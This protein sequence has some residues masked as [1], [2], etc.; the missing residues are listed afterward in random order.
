M[1]TYDINCLAQCLEGIKGSQNGTQSITYKF[2][3]EGRLMLTYVTVMH[4]ASDASLQLQTQRES[5]R[6]IS[7]INDAVKTV[8]ASYKEASGKSLKV[9][10]SSTDDSVEIISTT[11]HSPRKVGYYR[12]H[13]I[14]EIG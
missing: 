6:S 5:E 10:E 7:M 8:K 1:I 4:I 12:R 3:G 9:K 2:P 11:F 13:V 14:F